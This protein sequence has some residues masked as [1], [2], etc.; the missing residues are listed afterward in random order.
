M[1]VGFMILVLCW[2][3][4][5]LGFHHQQPSR[6]RWEGDKS[7]GKAVSRK[8]KVFGYHSCWYGAV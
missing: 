8:N 5:S 6:G 7:I 1:A 3:D 4:L 2:F